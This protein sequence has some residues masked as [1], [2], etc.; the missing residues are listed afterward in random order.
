MFYIPSVF[1]NDMQIELTCNLM[2]EN[3]KEIYNKNLQLYSDI[4]RNRIYYFVWNSNNRHTILYYNI[5]TNT[6]VKVLSNI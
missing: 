1:N 3:E 2:R 6:T 5:T 4:V